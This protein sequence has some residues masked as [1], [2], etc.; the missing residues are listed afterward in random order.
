LRSR[1][2]K[3]YCP[4][5]TVVL[6]GLQPR[7]HG[8]VA[9][10]LVRYLAPDVLLV[11]ATQSKEHLEQL[12]CTVGLVASGVDVETFQ[13]VSD[14]RRRELRVHYKLD[15]DWP[16]VLDGG[17]L[18]D[19]RGLRALADLAGRGQCQVELVDSSST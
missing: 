10:R 15:P 13:S 18:K 6:V 7:S 4:A 1:I 16:T 3:S 14:A 12:G 8:R 9:G 11:Q 2:L 5:A 19:G 17:H